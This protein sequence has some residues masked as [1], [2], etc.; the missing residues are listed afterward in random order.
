MVNDGN[1]LAGTAGPPG[2]V[3][4]LW[5]RVPRSLWSL[6]RR[7]SIG[8]G[9]ASCGRNDYLPPGHPAARQ[10]CLRCAP[11]P[12]RSYKSAGGSFRECSGAT[13]PEG[14][15]ARTRL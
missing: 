2:S 8:G 14:F 5:A 12:G 1:G 15:L 3:Y 11:I 7:S 9:C 6:L 13:A 4:W 10:A